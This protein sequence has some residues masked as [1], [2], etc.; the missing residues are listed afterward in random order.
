[1]L[2]LNHGLSWRCCEEWEWASWLVMSSYSMERHVL[3]IKTPTCSRWGMG[4]RFHIDSDPMIRG[5]ASAGADAL[6]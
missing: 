1:M 2:K 5:S 3:S 6:A 4:D